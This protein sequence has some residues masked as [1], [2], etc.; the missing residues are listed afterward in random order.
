MPPRPPYPEYI[1]EF[2]DLTFGPNFKEL[3][4][5]SPLDDPHGD[6]LERLIEIMKKREPSMTEVHEILSDMKLERIKMHR[7]CDK[8]DQ[9]EGDLLD[10]VLSKLDFFGLAAVGGVNKAWR[11][12][13]EQEAVWERLARQSFSPAKNAGIYASFDA[14]GLAT[15]KSRCRL[16]A[17]AN[18]SVPF[19]KYGWGRD[20]LEQEYEF[21][22]AMTDGAGNAF[23]APAQLWEGSRY[24]SYDPR[25]QFTLKAGF[26][27]PVEMHAGA[28]VNDYDPYSERAEGFGTVKAD[29]FAR[30][31]RDGKVAHLAAIDYD[32]EIELTDPPPDHGPISQNLI[33]GYHSASLVDS[34]MNRAL[35]DTLLCLRT[36]KWDVKPLWLGE[37][38]NDV[39]PSLSYNQTICHPRSKNPEWQCKLKWP[40]GYE[41][42]WM[43]ELSAIVEDPKKTRPEGGEEGSAG[44]LRTGKWWGVRLDFMWTLGHTPGVVRGVRDLDDDAGPRVECDFIAQALAGRAIDW[45]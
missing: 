25:N 31:L 41:P 42:S 2:M 28:V 30:R 22:I 3:E 32:F 5:K 21:L 7:N 13:V 20:V 15:W 8:W 33:C 4:M 45:V 6:R 12:A 9:L 27:S 10:I 26:P 18:V 16:L 34:G 29:V 40:E 35:E 38:V 44:A 39:F 36:E 11:A 24:R 37:H 23:S 43:V 19:P 1:Y 17:G 14:L